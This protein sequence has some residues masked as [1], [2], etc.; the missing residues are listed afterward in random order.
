MKQP[1]TSKPL[2]NFP[3]EFSINFLQSNEISWPEKARHLLLG[4]IM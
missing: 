4:Q 1:S 2:F 3:L